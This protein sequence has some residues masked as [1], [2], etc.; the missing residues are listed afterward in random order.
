VLVD[1]K[2]DIKA[3]ELRDFITQDADEVQLDESIGAHFDAV[4]GATTQTL[5]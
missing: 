2:V 3:R 4:S 5:H 1:G